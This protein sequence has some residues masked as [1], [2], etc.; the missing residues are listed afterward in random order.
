MKLNLN[1][2]KSEIHA[3]S[4]STETS[5]RDKRIVRSLERGGE[6]RRLKRGGFLVMHA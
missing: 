2:K 3:I 5:T 6:G 1:E 4:F